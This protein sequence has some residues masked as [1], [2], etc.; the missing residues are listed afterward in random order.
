MSLDHPTVALALKA[1][2]TLWLAAISIW[3]R[4]H[5]RVPNS[6][7]LPVLGGALVWRIYEA[8]AHRSDRILFIIVAWIVLFMMWRLHI[9]GG[10]DAKFLMAMLALFPTTP[11]LV[12]LSLTVLL[13][14]TPL[15][16][17]KYAR[18]GGRETVHALRRRLRD[19]ALLPTA[20]E[21]Q[22]EGR[23]HCWTYALAGVIY[24]WWVL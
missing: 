9:L 10:G 15:L 11:F 1:A 12:L 20:E 2:A 3:D 17:I 5:R 22:T 16:I 6:L 7:V 4:R 23:P 18:R 13:V 21:L 8:I 19:G 14:R 24:L